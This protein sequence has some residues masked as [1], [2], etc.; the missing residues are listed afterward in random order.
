MHILAVILV[1]FVA[2]EHIGIMGM[3][4]LGSNQFISK[5]F[6]MPLEIVSKPEMRAALSNQGIYNGFV[7]LA[8]MLA[9]FIPTGTIM[10]TLVL[11]F[12]GFVIFAAI[13]GTI[14]VYK[15][16]LLFQ[17]GPAILAFLLGIFFL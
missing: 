10:K 3:E 11:C 17:G 13:F 4:M 2:I 12:L 5:S 6:N 15:R 8:L 9:L 7:A 1:L 16:I 14:T